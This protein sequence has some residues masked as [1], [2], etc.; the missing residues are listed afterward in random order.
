VGISKHKS[1]LYGI[2]NKLEIS[3]CYIVPAKKWYALCSIIKTNTP[4]LI[5]ELEP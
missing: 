2:E 5:E 4:P 1:F 3:R